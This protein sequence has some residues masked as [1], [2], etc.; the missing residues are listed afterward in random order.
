M[1]NLQLKA[2]VTRNCE[3]QIEGDEFVML[4][5]DGQEIYRTKTV[6]EASRILLDKGALEVK[7]S[8][9]YFKLDHDG[10]VRQVK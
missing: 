2:Q 8:Y 4:N 9:N 3:L 5:S 1:R 10:T 6:Y 7:H